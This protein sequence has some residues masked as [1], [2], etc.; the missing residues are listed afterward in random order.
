MTHGH[1]LR[2]AWPRRWQQGS[3][4]T[5]AGLAS[6]YSQMGTLEAERG[7]DLQQGITWHLKALAIR[8]QLRSPQALINLRAL[9][10]HRTSL[11][12]ELFDRQLNQAAGGSGPA[13]T[14]T[15]LID[16][17]QAADC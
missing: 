12:T 15:A 10:A 11:G 7:G 9:A 6:G 8:L 2:P 4:Q 17:V 3:Q 5:P 13:E 1:G 14:I 16:Q